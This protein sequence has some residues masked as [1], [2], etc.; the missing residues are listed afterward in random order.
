MQLGLELEGRLR[1]A[2]QPRILM[3]HQF[4]KMAEHDRVVSIQEVLLS[5][6]DSKAAQSATSQSRKAT[7]SEPPQKPDTRA[8][9]STEAAPAD[10]K[11]SEPVTPPVQTGAV[12]RKFNRGGESDKG[13]RDF[14]TSPSEGPAGTDLIPTNA[15]GGIREH[16]EKIVNAVEA[17]SHQMASMLAEVE[18]A[19]LTGNR[20]TVHLPA[21]RSLQLKIFMDK[22]HLVEAA[23]L[24][25]TSWR[26]RVLPT[27]PE[28]QGSGVHINR[29]RTAKSEVFDELMETFK[30]EEY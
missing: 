15:L 3:E 18:L 29:A 23:I 25:V 10:V 2:Q 17:K 20:L 16:W 27:I 26:I 13:E 12:E 1:Y 21:S 4:L 22:R 11:A 6:G 14:P 19:D 5:L 7:S 30:G 9:S 24:D 8:D 28:T